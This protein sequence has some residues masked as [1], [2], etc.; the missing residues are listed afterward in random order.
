MLSEERAWAA[1]RC[2]GAACPC[3]VGRES[4][5]SSPA[6]SLAA[7]QDMALSLLTAF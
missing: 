4:P 7:C 1:C 2:G 6:S 3:G 5:E